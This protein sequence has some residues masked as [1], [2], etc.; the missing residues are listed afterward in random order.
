MGT[1][2]GTQP[3]T[4]FEPET[5]VR[6][7]TS[8]QITVLDPIT[9]KPILIAPKP[10]TQAKPTPTTPPAPAP[11]PALS[12]GSS[13]PSA[14]TDTDTDTDSIDPP[15]IS[16]SPIYLLS[17]SWLQ[18]NDTSFPFP[19]FAV[20]DVD[21]IIERVDTRL[22]NSVDN[23]E[24]VDAA[25][26]REEERRGRRSSTLMEVVESSDEEDGGLQ[27]K[28]K[29]KEK[30]EPTFWVDRNGNEWLIYH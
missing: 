6:T 7:P 4:K 11:T 19:P 27:K 3:Q 20:L 22:W 16:P 25:T 21:D 26:D 2:T 29:E 5:E 15:L 13:I 18:S 9:N 24:S 17:R 30:Q 28:E 1:R 14:D 23:N 12:N 8:A 10:L